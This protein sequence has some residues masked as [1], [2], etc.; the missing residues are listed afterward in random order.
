[1]PVNQKSGNPVVVVRDGAAYANSQL[2]LG[3]NV[4]EA[5]SCSKT[6]FEYPGGARERGSRVYVVRTAEGKVKVGRSGNVK[7][8][9]G[10][11]SRSGGFIVS[12]WACTPA[13]TNASAIEAE[14][15]REFKSVVSEWLDASFDEV[16]ALISGL[17]WAKDSAVNAAE[18]VENAHARR[19]RH[20]HLDPS[21]W[22]VAR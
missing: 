17:R 11:L 9:L 8:R 14:A 1:M 18:D 12:A 20:P 16:C 3:H 6:G 21:N 15:K 7:H 10:V 19:A 5:P 22:S 13:I 4:A 2:I